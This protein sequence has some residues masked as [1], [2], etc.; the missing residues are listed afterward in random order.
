MEWVGRKSRSTSACDTRGRRW[1]TCSAHSSTPNPS[2][3]LVTDP[4]C[5]VW[6]YI[7]IYI[8]TYNMYTCAHCLQGKI[9]KYILLVCTC[10]NSTACCL[11]TKPGSL[12]LPPPL[13]SKP[14]APPPPSNTPLHGG[15]LFSMLRTQNNLI[16]MKEV[17]N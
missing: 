10:G 15:S 16:N 3:M 4:I 1:L 12:L 6:S 13:F 14:V 2:Q 9:Q 8:Y 7:Y 11:V 17:T 5:V